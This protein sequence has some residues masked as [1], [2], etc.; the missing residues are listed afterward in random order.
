MKYPAI[1]FF[2]FLRDAIV[3]E[4]KAMCLINLICCCNTV[5][6]NSRLS[7]WKVE[8]IRDQRN[9]RKIV[10]ELNVMHLSFSLVYA[11]LRK[12]RTLHTFLAYSLLSEVRYFPSRTYRVLWIKLCNFKTFSSQALLLLIQRSPVELLWVQ[13]SVSMKHNNSRLVSWQPEYLGW[14]ID[15]GFLALGESVLSVPWPRVVGWWKSSVISHTEAWGR[16]LP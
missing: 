9:A 7:L 6:I 11:A 16:P 14:G 15:S 4:N 3:P 12:R 2:F 5:L 8:T 10:R 13:I 1:A